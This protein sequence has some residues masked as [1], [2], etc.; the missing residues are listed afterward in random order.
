MRVPLSWL[1]DFNDC[2]LPAEDL[3][4][5]LTLSGLEVEGIEKIGVHSHRVLVAEITLATDHPQADNLRVVRLSLGG[6]E[7]VTAVTGAPNIRAGMEGVK[8]ATALPG[9][10]LVDAKAETFDMYTVAAHPVMGIESNAVVC[11]EKELGLSDDHSGV[12]I[13]ESK[14][15]KP[16]DV[17]IDHEKP[18]PD[19]EADV[20]LDIAILPNYGRCLSIVGMAREVAALT[21]TSFQLVLDAEHVVSNPNAFDIRI[22]EPDL[23]S[24]YSGYVLGGVSVRPS[25]RWMQR[26]LALSGHKPINN[27]VDVTNY[28]MTELGQPMH[29]FDLDRL[30]ARNIVVRRARP[31]ET[32]HTLD[33][34]P[35]GD[36]GDGQE[37]PPPRALDESTLL[38][39]SGEQP[40]AVAGVIGGLDS[41]IYPDTTNILLESANFDAV[42]IRKAMSSLKVT[43]ESSY[44]FS[45]EVDPALTT[46]AIQRATYL[47][48]EIADAQ[49]AGALRDCHPRPRASREIEITPEQ[50]CRSLGMELESDEIESALRRLGFRIEETEEGREEGKI[51]VDV[52]GF[53]PD[54]TIPADVAE[55]VI[56][57]VGF[58]RLELK[59]LAE[60]L[61]TQRR[62]V[63]W[64]IKQTIR[65]L[66][67]G[68]G[69]QDVINYSLIAA[70][71]EKRLHIESDAKDHA[72]DPPYVEMMNPTGQERSVMRRTL[73]GGLM[74]TVVR[75]HRLRERIALF[76]IGIV[77]HP[78]D[79]DG[80]LPGEP[81]HLSIV[82]TGPV[83][84]P[85]W[86]EQ[87]PREVSFFDMKGLVEGLLSR[88][89]IEDS[90]FVRANAAPY[91]PGISAEVMI[92]DRRAGVLG[93]LH[94]QV[95][96]NYGLDKRTVIA[97]EL[98]LEP[99]IEAARSTYK[100]QA[101]TRFPPVREDLTLV[102]DEDVPA[103]KVTDTI[104]KASGPL[105]T[106]IYLTALFRG[107]QLGEGKKSLSFRLVFCVEGRSLL[108]EEVNEIRDTMVPELE[109]KL[110]ARLRE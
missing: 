21:R 42:A 3:A 47:L 74:E 57:V 12:L 48:K 53:R 92:G 90:S 38:I 77:W 65:D 43:T 37:T 95:V 73:L 83:E 49:P 56:R 8:V 23:C 22:E 84:E 106:E 35:D 5:R 109:T 16:G 55:E 33:Q 64:E 10:I 79:G 30:P 107:E 19:G 101:F 61:P 102:V 45:R 70:A 105:L 32:M 9:A 99:L 50:I 1:R 69:L 93:Q 78:E 13:V 71:A 108:Q 66:L 88:L 76:E 94:P 34:K 41:Q 87:Q 100:F 31:G 25:P 54:V 81:Q 27:L 14:K 63:P 104:R 46:A 85:T 96:E 11:S 80:I 97:C 7:T 68:A 39:T 2:D 28:V 82:L 15:A 58:D 75:N 4:E 91:H 110:G 6:D 20:V 18:R 44:R 67:V 24:R 29:A 17:L 62:N 52:P 89:H 36:A 59:R 26:R 40:V 60:P 86:G 72:K 103:A 51:V 98:D